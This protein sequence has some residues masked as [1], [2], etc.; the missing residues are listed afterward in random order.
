SR[1]GKSVSCASLC[2]RN[3]IMSES[4]KMTI[5]LKV[6]RQES[7]QTK[8]RF[9]DYTVK[10]VSPDMSFLEM[11]DVLNQE[12]IIKGEEP[13]VF[14]HDCREGICGTCSMTIDGIPHGPEKGVATC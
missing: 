11:F 7:A 6:W 5:H 9:V 14:D 10:N 13:I 2:E 8:G 3:G 1:F 4:K 12:L